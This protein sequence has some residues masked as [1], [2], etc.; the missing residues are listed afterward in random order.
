MGSAPTLTLEDAAAIGQLP[1][2]A[3]VAPVAPGAAQIVYGANNWNTGVLGTTPGYLDC[4]NW[5]IAKGRMFNESEIRGEARVA[6]IGQTVS[7]NLFGSEDPVGK[8]IR[9]ANRPFQVIGLLSVKGQSL[10]GQDQ[11]DTVLI[12]VSTALHQ[13]FG[14]QFA[15]SVRLIMAQAVSPQAMNQAQSDM[16]ALLR[17]RHH[18]SRPSRMISASVISPRS[19]AP[20]Q[21][22]RASCRCCLA[23]L[24]R[25][26]W[27]WVVSAS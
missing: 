21:T 17:Q 19:P 2:I 7:T 4:H 12:P 3:A 1:D 11:D 5:P 9:I 25:Y 14:S 22:P 16:E 8:T 20:L 15:N 10:G 27:L 6:V 24:L 26:R 18:C 23:P 13:L